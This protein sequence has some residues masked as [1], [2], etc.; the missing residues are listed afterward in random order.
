MSEFL[1]NNAASL[2]SDIATIEGKAA[3]AQD[4]ADTDA[5]NYANL[6]GVNLDEELADMIKYQ[7]AFEASARIFSA[8]SD[9]MATII[10][11]V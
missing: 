1:T 3:T 2:G 8:A 5:T 9:L 7:R 11:M 4:I 6:I 10:G